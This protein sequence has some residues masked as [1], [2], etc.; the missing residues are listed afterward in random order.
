MPARR[1]RSMPL[2]HS[3]QTFEFARFNHPVIIRHEANPEFWL[4]VVFVS[5]FYNTASLTHTLTSCL[6]LK[7]RTPSF[8]G[9]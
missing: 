8:T 2:S 7:V 5:V 1:F 9:K 4:P 6:S 3:R